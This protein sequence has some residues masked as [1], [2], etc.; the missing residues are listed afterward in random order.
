MSR[1]GKSSA[2]G[3]RI[4]DLGGGSFR[5]SW[6]IDR[7]YRNSRLR[8]PTGYS[9]VTDRDGAI[10]FAKKWDVPERFC[11]SLFPAGRAALEGGDN[12]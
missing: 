10:R 2:Y 6:T 9:R 3:H 12:A 1:Y 11:V 4:L 8:H 7:Y 5:V